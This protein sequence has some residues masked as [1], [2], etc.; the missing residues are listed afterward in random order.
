MTCCRLGRRGLHLGY[1][2][3]VASTHVVETMRFFDAS[4]SDSRAPWSGNS[5]ERDP[6]FARDLP[7][8]QKMPEIFRSRPRDQVCLPARDG[9]MAKL[10]E[11]M[12]T[13]RA[14]VRVLVVPAF[15]VTDGKA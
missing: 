10:F 5:L 3:N 11:Q 9:L 4:P 2:R 15:G 6:R 12:P 14:T 7:A 13:C 8:R 1:F